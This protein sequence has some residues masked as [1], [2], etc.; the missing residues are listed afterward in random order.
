MVGRCQKKKD[1]RTFRVD[2]ISRLEMGQKRFEVPDDFD[3]EAYR[4][5]RLFV[6]AADAEMTCQML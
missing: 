1:T 5:E 2:R 4:R 3:L 6:P